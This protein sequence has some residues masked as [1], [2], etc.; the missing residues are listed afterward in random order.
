MYMLRAT[1]A[2]IYYI[3][4]KSFAYVKYFHNSIVSCNYVILEQT[5]LYKLCNHLMKC[6]MIIYQTLKEKYGLWDY[7]QNLGSNVRSAHKRWWRNLTITAERAV[8]VKNIINA[9][10]YRISKSCRA[11]TECKLR[12]V[13]YWWHWGWLHL[14]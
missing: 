13:I 2:V 14:C 6:P 9:G 12:N 7:I 1:V 4:K 11:C 10:K 3:E 8:H 5:S